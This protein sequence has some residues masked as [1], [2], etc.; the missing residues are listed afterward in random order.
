VFMLV[1][2][3]SSRVC[4]DFMIRLKNS[5]FWTIEFSEPDC[6]DP[7]S[8]FKFSSWAFNSGF[9]LCSLLAERRLIEQRWSSSLFDWILERTSKNEA[10]SS[11]MS[12]LVEWNRSLFDSDWSAD[13]W[14]PDSKFSWFW[15]LISRRFWFDCA[16]AWS[17]RSI[18]VCV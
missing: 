14:L 5:S 16:S 15:F 1:R 8:S 12:V 7:F 17:G 9:S 18:A 6:R 3:S 2:W 4:W 10:S 13:L 11:F